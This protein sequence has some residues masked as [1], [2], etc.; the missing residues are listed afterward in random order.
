MET[1]D[2]LK[3][4]TGN[5]DSRHQPKPTYEA[6]SSDRA[7]SKRSEIKAGIIHK[8]TD[9]LLLPSPIVVGLS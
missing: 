1:G 6:G 2:Y 7:G 5:D 4:Q 8:A 9:S 3:Y